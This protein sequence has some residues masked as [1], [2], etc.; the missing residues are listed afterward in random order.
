MLSIRI[1]EKI[2]KEFGKGAIKYAKASDALSQL[3]R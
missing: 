2:E 1:K 3:K